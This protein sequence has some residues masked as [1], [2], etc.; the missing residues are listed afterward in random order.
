MFNWLKRDTS[1]VPVSQVRGLIGTLADIAM[2]AS[3]LTW[4]NVWGTIKHEQ[5]YSGNSYAALK[6]SA[7]KCALDIYT[8]MVGTV[9]RR[10]YALESG[11]QK[12]LRIVATTDHPASRLFSH[13]FHPELPSDEALLMIVYD[14]L[15]DGNAYFIKEPDVQGRTSRLYYVHPSRVP[16]GN[17]FRST[18]G[19]EKLTNGRMA[20]QGELLYRIDTGLSSRDVKSEPLLIS[21]SD[22]VHFKN[23]VLD[24]EHHRGVGFIES[25]EISRDLYRAAEEFGWRFYSRGIATQMFLT[26]DNRLAPEVLK[27]VEANFNDDPNAPLESIFKTRV[28][29][30]GLKPVHMGIPFQHLQ[31]IETRAFSVEDIARGLTIPPVLL[32]SY[33]GTKAGDVPLS[34][35]IAMFIQTGIGPLLSRIAQQF[36]TECLP[37]PSQMLFGFEFEHLYLYRTVIG[38]FT[39]ALRNLFEIG[40]IDRQYGAGL[41]GMHIDPNDPANNL[42]YLPVNLM[43]VQ[44]SLHLEEG[45]DLNNDMLEKQIEMQQQTNDGMVTEEKYTAVQKQAEA[46]SPNGD[47]M[48]QSPSKDNIDKRIRNADERIRNA[49]LNVINGL[50]QYEARVLDQKKQSRPDDFETARTEFYAADGK[51]ATM[52]NDQLEPWED[53]ILGMPGLMLSPKQLIPVW[54]NKQSLPDGYDTFPGEHENE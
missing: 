11:T 8:G 3:N 20:A 54:L 24:T 19:Q 38:E 45:A 5:M 46:K 42:R 35:A 37:L 33:M 48:D 1:R 22:I 34:E 21:R 9:P 12:K 16:R 15:M 32:H 39:T 23:K 4:Q 10:M 47:K 30:Q 28:L 51:F 41:L 44:H 25:S 6:L 7:V 36:R 49:Y 52:L 2:N 14:M 18:A 43:T 53:V 26:T 17:I 27:R 50:K 13:Y 40:M 31:F 29:E